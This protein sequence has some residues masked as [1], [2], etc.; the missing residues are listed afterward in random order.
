MQTSTTADRRRA[1]FTLLE[2]LVVLA[3]IALVMAI[4][5]PRL[6]TPSSLAAKENA[7]RHLAAALRDT[8]A[9]AVARNAEIDLTVDVAERRYRIAGGAWQSLDGS[10]RLALY[11]AQSQLVDETQGAIRFFPDGSSSGGHLDVSQPDDGDEAVRVRVDWLT[12]TVD[13]AH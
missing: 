11:T 7:A 8:R 12:G 10:L 4:A 13:V 3:V 2:L 5:A 1:G 6:V 9:I